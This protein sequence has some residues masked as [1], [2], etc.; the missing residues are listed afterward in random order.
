MPIAF[1][2]LDHTLLDGDTNKLW[3]E[4][5]VENSHVPD[6]TLERQA[7]FMEDYA[8]QQLDIDNYL[9]FHLSI[10]ALRPVTDWMPIRNVF[11]D[12]VIMPRI[13]QAARSMITEH[14]LQGHKMAIVTA[15]HSFLSE[16]VGDQLGLEVI[17]PV[18]EIVNG[19]FTGNIIGPPAFREQK[20]IRVET[21][22]GARLNT[23][24][25]VPCHFYSDSA[26]DIPLLQKV[27]HPVT[28]NPDPVLA[29]LAKTNG[30]PVLVWSAPPAH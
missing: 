14:R 24:A 6:T 4:Y 13:G 18:V 10:L 19:Q 2:D 12:K 11:I 29:S 30:W 26:N 28:V 9:A 16:P 27:S 15:T 22:L 5:L 8:Q 25:S 3:I 21:W 20:I 17:A 23:D 1:F 7:R